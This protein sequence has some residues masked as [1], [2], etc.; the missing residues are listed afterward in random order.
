MKEEIAIVLD[1]LKGGYVDDIRPFHQKEPIAQALGRDHF[2]LL[3]LVPRT[4][5]QLSP[6]DE[7]Y[8]GEGKR[9]KIKYIKRAIPYSKLTQTAKTELPFI[10]QK[11]V[12]TNEK[13]FVDFY[14]YSNPISVRAHQL[15]LLPGLGKKQAAKILEE[16]DI[17]PFKNFN[18]IKQRVSFIPN[19][20]K[21]IIDRILLEI[22]GHE[23]H[24]L[25]VRN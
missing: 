17:K 21:A 8:I 16:R 2:T 6:Y 23:R 10:I 11:L 12:E 4:G 24:R 20:E 25:F 13:K 18:D 15:E 1:Y 9:E 19:P 7:A 14:N 22:E 3:E 5:V